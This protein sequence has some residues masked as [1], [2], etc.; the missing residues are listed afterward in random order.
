MSKGAETSVDRWH[1]CILSLSGF[2]E[3]KMGF[4]DVNLA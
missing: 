4:D 3:L 1:G 2:L